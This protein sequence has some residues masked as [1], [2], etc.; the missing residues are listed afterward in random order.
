MSKR[1]DIPSGKWNIPLLGQKLAA[2]INQW[3]VDYQFKSFNLLKLNMIY[4]CDADATKNS[5]MEIL[6]YIP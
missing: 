3:K 2:S 1:I 5:A 4:L 6:K